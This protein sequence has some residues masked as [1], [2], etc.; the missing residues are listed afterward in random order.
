MFT[1]PSCPICGEPS[2][3]HL[4]TCGQGALPPELVLAGLEKDADGLKHHHVYKHT[5]P[6][7]GWIPGVNCLF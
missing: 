7:E 2:G 4:K 1:S 6:P 3:F 5:P